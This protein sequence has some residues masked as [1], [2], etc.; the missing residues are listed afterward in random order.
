MLHFLICSN[1]VIVFSTGTNTDSDAPRRNEKDIVYFNNIIL[2]ER[3]PFK[4]LFKIRCIIRNI[5][6][7]P[8][9]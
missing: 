6:P 1:K 3:S 4:S 5:L 8:D 2:K 7:T 9:N